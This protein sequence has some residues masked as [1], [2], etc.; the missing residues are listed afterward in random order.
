MSFDAVKRLERCSFRDNSLLIS[1][2]FAVYIETDWQFIYSNILSSRN[3]FFLAE[4]QSAEP[5]LFHLPPGTSV[6]CF[7]SFFMWAK[8]IPNAVSIAACDAST[9]R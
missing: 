9:V 7:F 1:D 6:V 8:R 5:H 3:R 4:Y 2:K